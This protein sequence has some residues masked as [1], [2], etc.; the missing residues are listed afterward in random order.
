MKITDK[1][2]I[3][4]ILVIT[5]SNIGDIVLTTPVLSVL[6][7]RFPYAGIDVLGGPNGKEIFSDIRL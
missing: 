3:N 4:R 2:A 1:D 5:L 7:K 6:R